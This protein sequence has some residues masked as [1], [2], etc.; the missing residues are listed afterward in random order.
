M[1]HANPSPPPA[2]INLSISG[3]QI[4]QK[5]KKKMIRNLKDSVTGIDQVKKCILNNVA[6]VMLKTLTYIIDL[7]F[8]KANSLIIS[9]EPS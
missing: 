4:A 9:S 5:L 8:N 3:P 7:P 6:S 2:K 1:N